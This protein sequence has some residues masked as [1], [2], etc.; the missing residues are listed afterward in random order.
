MRNA[1]VVLG[2]CVSFLAAGELHAG[3]QSAPAPVFLNVGVG[4]QP[5]RH[6]MNASSSFPLFDE[7]ATVA[8]VQQ[9]RN[10][11]LIEIGGGVHLSRQFAVGA[12]FSTFGRPGAGTLTASIPDPIVYS[13]PSTVVRDASD[14]HHTERALHLQ[15]ALSVPVSPR[16]EVMLSGGPSFTRV[17]QEVATASIDTATQAVSVSRSS[18]SGTAIGFNA[19]AQ[20]TY[21]LAE[22]YGIGLFAGYAGG[23]VDLADAKGVTVGGLR[24]GLALQVRF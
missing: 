17:S 22:R 20:G 10:G 18:Q 3:A 21:F 14:L 5:Q 1:T 9:I 23:S 2:L 11:A 6:T 15:A 8:A 19:G 12:A 16:F 13:Q 4:A 24:T 7:T